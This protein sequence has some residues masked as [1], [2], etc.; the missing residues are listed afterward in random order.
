MNKASGVPGLNRNDAYQLKVSTPK[1]PEQ[2]KIVERL[3]AVQ[4]HKKLLLKQKS[5]LKELFDSV[6][7]KCMKGDLLS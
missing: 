5:L 3:S 6:L 4:E 7:D 1:L 2:E